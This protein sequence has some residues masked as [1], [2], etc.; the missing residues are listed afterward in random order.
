MPRRRRRLP[1]ELRSEREED[2][3]R[4]VERFIEDGGRI[5]RYSPSGK[6]VTSYG[7]DDST[8]KED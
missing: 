2:R 3:E 4:A 7:I 8:S 5:K 6:L 1:A